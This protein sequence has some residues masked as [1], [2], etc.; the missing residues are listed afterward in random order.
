MEVKYSKYFIVHKHTFELVE[1]NNKNK[2]NPSH[3]FIRRYIYIY[4]IYMGIHNTIQCVCLKLLFHKLYTASPRIL[5][6]AASMCFIL[7]W[8]PELNYNIN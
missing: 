7:I 2:K 4:Y 5:L 1:F 3:S 6:Y 8:I